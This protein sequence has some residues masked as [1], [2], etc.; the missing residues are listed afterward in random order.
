MCMTLFVF[1][2]ILLLVGFIE[3]SDFPVLLDSVSHP[4]G[5]NF[6]QVGSLL[7][8]LLP[9][10][11]LAVSTRVRHH[12]IWSHVQYICLSQTE[13]ILWCPVI[14][15]SICSNPSL[16]SPYTTTVSTGRPKRATMDPVSVV[17]MTPVIARHDCLWISVCPLHQRS[18]F[19]W[20]TL[21]F[22]LSI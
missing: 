22:I 13:A 14:F 9:R 21:G 4:A 16:A 12:V 2:N 10:C 15:K 19:Q 7:R 3:P 17:F 6:Y 5:I 18:R 1:N 8:F 11:G 20:T